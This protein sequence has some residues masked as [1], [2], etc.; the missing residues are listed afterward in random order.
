MPS[1]CSHLVPRELGRP[2]GAVVKQ[3]AN[4]DKMKQLTT[5]TVGYT[6]AALALGEMMARLTTDVND[7]LSAGG[8][9]LAS[10]G[11]LFSGTTARTR[12]Q[13]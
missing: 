11:E 5:A 12:R 2:L 1:P 13:L 10:Q 8:G 4:S 9:E 6:T 7:F 3:V